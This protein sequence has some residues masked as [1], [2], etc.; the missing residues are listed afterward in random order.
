MPKRPK[1][2][3]SRLEVLHRKSAYMPPGSSVVAYSFGPLIA[4]MRSSYTA[5]NQ[6]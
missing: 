6:T 1:S 2:P 3:R 4:A 5:Y